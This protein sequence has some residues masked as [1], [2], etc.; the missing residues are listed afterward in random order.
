MALISKE[1]KDYMDSLGPSLY[2]EVVASIQC[3]KATIVF[4]INCTLSPEAI[5]YYRG[6]N[7]N[8]RLMPYTYKQ[9]R[10]LITIWKQAIIMT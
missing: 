7:L 6:V 3:K 1:E 4:F 8:I 2:S 9:G 10:A 5:E